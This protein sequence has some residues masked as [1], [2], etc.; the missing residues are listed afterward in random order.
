MPWMQASVGLRA[1]H[2]ARVLDYPDW[3]ERLSARAVLPRSREAILAL[4][5]QTDRELIEARRQR[6]REW[7]RLLEDG[8][9]PSIQDISDPGPELS[10]CRGEGSRL[11]P[12]QLYR[13]ARSLR[14]L[15]SFRRFI[16]SEAELVPALHSDL[17]EIEPQDALVSRIE[18]CV[19]PDG[20]V[21]DGASTE[22]ARIRRSMSQTRDRVR[23]TLE[24]LIKSRL[25]SPGEDPRP[26][27]RSGRLVLP[28]KR[29]R[30]AD[31]PGI[32]HDE[33]GTGKT[34]FVE[35]ME[36]VE[37]NNRVAGLSAEEREE[38][39]RVL[40]ELSAWVRGA[41]PDIEN[42]TQRFSRMEIP[43][44]LAREFKGRPRA[45]AEERGERIRLAAARHPLL[46]DYLGP[47]VE[48][49]PLDLSL[50]ED[51]RLLLVSGPNTG[52]KTVML[53][54]LGLMAFLNQ[55]GSP[56]PAGDGCEL[57]IF[58]HILA[59]I[60]DEQSL[61]DSQSTFSAHLK[62]L[63]RMVEEAGPG[64]LILVDEIGDG[65][66]PEEG[67]AL[68]R[69]AMENWMQSG[70]RILITTHL[71][72]LKGFAQETEG[73]ANAS[74]EFD[75]EARRPLYVL[76]PGV[77][78]SSRAMATARRLGL[79]GRVLE[80]AESLLGEDA[81][82][83]DALLTRLEEESVRAS[84][85]REEGE[86]HRRRFELLEADYMKRMREVRKEERRILA[87][88]RKDGERFL[89]EARRQVEA[90]V[91]AIRESDADRKSISQAR[92][93]VDEL[94][95]E[96]EARG[97]KP[98]AHKPLENWRAGDRVRM[99]STGKIVE[100]LESG[101]SGR[102]RV[103]MEGV[104]LVLSKSDLTPLD[105]SEVQSAKPRPG[106]VWGLGLPSTELESFRLDLRG[107]AVDEALDELD[108][109]LDAAVLGG[110][111]F[112]EILHGKGTGA[113]RQ[114]IRER[115]RRDPRVKGFNLADQ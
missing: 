66:D 44:A 42:L 77:P 57:P 33:S 86:A 53:K 75:P 37:L 5:P 103:S 92:D 27:V 97:P 80:R 1:S 71:G 34:L 85:A 45:W 108:S 107:Q 54:T 3:L 76:R 48:L 83:M 39:A 18:S 91:Q 19:G 100:I 21:L 79:D 26:M 69:A 25:A 94:K 32:V 64:T 23:G 110:Y 109:F 114:A 74:M 38:I 60:G 14:A 4:M 93:K 6:V 16:L 78:G 65:T 12:E 84:E 40:D 90:A 82:K 70:A 47:G 72:G 8:H 104:A 51:Q 2:A 73:A 52:G 115:L 59:D 99:L 49:V 106:E 112:V 24:D 17:G 28:V 58:D 89:E 98:E 50:E 113:L 62:H 56:L 101:G 105:P 55:I 87:E 96:I 43:L 95:S 35:P 111:D 20:E 31:L 7:L 29:E 41:A 13:L 30:K 61:R 88:S 36:T 10:A 15:D 9:D 22:L 11:G 68:A 81:L 63:V 102:L 46:E 67:T